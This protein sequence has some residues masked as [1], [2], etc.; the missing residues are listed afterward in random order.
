[1]KCKIC[2]SKTKLIYKNLYDNRHG[3]R[4]RFDIHICNVCG[5][6]QTYPQLRIKNMSRIYSKYYPRKNINL[7]KVKKSGNNIPTKFQ[8]W[9][10]GLNGT[11]HFYVKSGDK[12]LDI[13]SGTGYSLVLIQSLGGEAWGLDPDN[14]AEN[15]AKKLGLKFHKGFIENC[16][17]PKNYF[18]LITAS[19]VIEHVPEPLKFLKEC[20][21]FLKP[22]GKIILSTPNNNAL[23]EKLWK[24][25]WL[26]WHIPYHL[27]HFNKKTLFY[28]A[29]HAGLKIGWSKTVTPNLWTILQI[30]S[31]LNNVKEGERDLMW[32]GVQ[33]KPARKNGAQNFFKKALSKTVPLIEKLLIINRLIDKLG[34][35][36]NLV[37][38]LSQ[39]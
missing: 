30:K 25:K 32:D 11:C 15:A 26:H 35:G 1:M 19:Q 34:L 17:F 38:E 8:R 4:G 22:N 14:N 36:E 7:D 6:M 9:L 37:V 24:E 18:D 5:F 3:Y 20:R 33:H 31:W 2:G 21:K 29:K 12:V 39:E 13:G 23:Y 10:R 16:P 27:N 28:L